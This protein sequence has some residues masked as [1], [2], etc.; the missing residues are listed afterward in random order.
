MKGHKGFQKG[1]NGGAKGGARPGGG[2]PPS[3]F[4]EACRKALNEGKGDIFAREVLEG[5]DFRQHIGDGKVA[6]IP[7]QIKDRLKA[8][9]LLADRGYGKA[10]QP[11]SGSE[12]EGLNL[13]PTA[14]I[15]ELIEVIRGNGSGGAEE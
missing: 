10:N 3:W 7:P 12:G 14:A 15:R 13:L 6:K 9:E 5:K 11:I 4:A 8:F 2:R 1:E